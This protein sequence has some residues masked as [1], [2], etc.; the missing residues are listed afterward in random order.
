MIVTLQ[1]QGLQTL[2]Q[3]RAFVAG[4][5]LVSFTLSDRG[6]AHAWMGDTLRR[7]GYKNASRADRGVLRHYLAKVTGLSRAQLTRR[8]TQFLA[9]GRIAD[10]RRAP[11]VPF[12]R[13]YTAEDIRLLAEVD[14]LHGTLSG[15]TT[16]KLCE[17]AFA[18]HG[19]ARF[20]RLSTISNGHLYNL[21]RHQTYRAVRGSYDKTR[22]VKVNIGERRKPF[23]DGRP[24]YLRVDSVHQGDRDGIKGV[25][26]VNAVDEVTQFQCICAVEKISERF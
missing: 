23:P 26:L 16:R 5:V 4:N 7:F 1:T 8:I 14:A 19:D 20:E 15:S 2:E 6:S 13:R 17:R 11:A 9:G 10:R 24:G 12:A 21:R 3:V 18:V 22:P 25:Y